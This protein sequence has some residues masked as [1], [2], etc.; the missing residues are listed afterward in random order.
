VTTFGFVVFD[1]AFG[2][3]WTEIDRLNDVADNNVGDEV[4]RR[5]SSWLMG[6]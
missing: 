4:T 3:A 1:R 2:F 6:G 5:F